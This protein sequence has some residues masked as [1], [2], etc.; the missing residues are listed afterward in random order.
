MMTWKVNVNRC[1]RCGGCTSVCPVAA[2]ELRDNVTC[3]SKLCTCCGVCE[4]ACPVDAIK[5]T[6]P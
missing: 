1:I 5:V 2:L 3:D 4:K 6:K